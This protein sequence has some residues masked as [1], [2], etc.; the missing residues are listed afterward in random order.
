[1]T[2]IFPRAAASARRTADKAKP[3]R[4][5]PGGQM[6]PTWW[7]SAFDRV[8]T[9][10]VCCLCRSDGKTH[11]P[12]QDT[13]N[14]SSD[15]MGLPAGDFHQILPAGAAR[16]FQQIQELSGLAA[17]VGTGNALG[18]LRRL[19]PSVGFLG[20]SSLRGRLTFRRR[21]VARVC[22][23]LWPFGASRLVGLHNGLDGSFFWKIAHVVFSLGGDYRDDHINHSDSAQLQPD[24]A[25]NSHGLG[26]GKAGE[27]GF[28]IT[29]E[30]AKC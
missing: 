25:K 8:T 5:N 29:A 14:K 20:R 10:P 16:A 21:D 7:P 12:A 22:G 30:E 18:R 6:E 17:L 2:P 11:P 3:P 26:R 9:L 15:R 4:R 1:M 27:S 24:P 28:R 13:R 19:T 23:N